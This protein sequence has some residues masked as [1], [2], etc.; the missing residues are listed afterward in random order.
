MSGRA[1]TG[2][3]SSD[4][5]GVTTF[6]NETALAVGIAVNGLGQYRFIQSIEPAS[7][8]EMPRSMIVGRSKRNSTVRRLFIS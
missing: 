3:G 1:V 6:G 8:R 4:L 2:A 5:A 7:F